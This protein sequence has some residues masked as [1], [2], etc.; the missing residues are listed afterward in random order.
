[1]TDSGHWLALAVALAIGAVIGLERGWQRRDVSEGGR[2]AGI[3]TFTLIG[4]AGGLTGVFGERFGPVLV[5]VA[6]AALAGLL[7]MGYRR[8]LN[9][10]DDR[11]ITTEVAALVTFL[12]GALA[13]LEAPL[14]AMAGGVLTAAVLG[15][16]PPLHALLQR[17][18]VTELRAILQLA[19]ITAVILPLLPDQGYGPWG[20]L[21]PRT[22]WVMVVLISAIGFVGHFAV[23]LGGARRGILFTG[24]FAGLASSTALTLTLSRA[25]RDQRDYQPLFAAAVVMASTT[26]FPRILVLVGAIQPAMLAGL[27][28]PVAIITAVGATATLILAFRAQPAAEG[29]GQPPLQKPFELG[30]ALRFALLLAVVMVAGEGL[31]RYAGDVGVYLLSLVSGLTDVDAITLSLSRMASDGLS[32]TVAQQGIIIAAMANTAVKLG[33]AVG[34]ARGR[35]GWLVGAGLGSVIVAGTI[36]TGVTLWR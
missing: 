36:W 25:A 35:M 18:D 10:D 33:L 32:E 3:R 6:L 13:S 22:L 26:M 20:T 21:N 2:V 30:T 24:L 8:R 5:A 9:I 17:V 11:G 7:L 31:R 14:L 12:L 23:R 28:L 34:I 1:M 4:F 19:L 15:F 16:K 29:A 27:Y